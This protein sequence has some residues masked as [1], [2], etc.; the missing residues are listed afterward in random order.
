MKKK[1]LLLLV[2]V[3]ALFLVAC[4]G[5]KKDEFTLEGYA[6][7]QLV[8]LGTVETPLDPQTVYDSLTYTKEMFYGCYQLLGGES[9]QKKYASQTDY[10][11]Y[12][13]GKE[14][15]QITKVPYK[16]E[17]GERTFKTDLNYVEEYD[18]L[19]AYFYEK[20]SNSSKHVDCAY[21][22][23]NNKLVLKPLWEY[24]I[25]TENDTLKYG[26]IEDI[27]EYEFA[28]AGRSL[29][30]TM[31]DSSVNLLSGLDPD[32]ESIDIAI[33][34]VLSLNS[35]P[36]DIIDCIS[37]GYDESSDSR[38]YFETVDSKAIYSAV[39]KLEE[40][41]LFTFTIP[42]DGGTKTFQY[43]YFLCG[44]DGIVL[45]D[46]T[47]T[48][49]YNETYLTRT[50]NEI[51]S[52]LTEDQTDIL[53]EL[54]QQELEEIVTKKEDLLGDLT[55]AFTEADIK[56]TIDE[57]TGE[58]A[59]DSSVLFGGD[60]AVLTEDGK[61]F[62]NKFLE[63]YTSIIF[64]EKYDGF[65]SKTMV[66]GHTAPVSGGTYESGLPL[67]EERAN[68][69]KEYCVSTESGVDVSKLASSLEAVG[70]SNS[71]PVYD[72]NGEVD[73]AASRRVSFKFIINLEK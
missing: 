34:N 39:G 56:V 4:G 54:T 36:M 38:L 17:A 65:I 16:I 14:T 33:H 64:S 62:L 12:T 19:R 21:S 5:K 57:A 66:E 20:D 13:V 51:N 72:E 69:V 10:M 73:M 11:N 6:K 31:G 52:F 68:N 26:F 27:W 9:A 7:K 18:W 61:T 46:G 15:M 2:S 45:T 23:E 30:L 44:M 48:Y 35:K 42:V 29:T 58:L 47:N 22:V 25:D 49:Y 59:M 55:N 32:G 28:F 3:M 63:V 41:G 70:Y 24:E 67:S 50:Q 43:V 1:I 60:S 37:L 71:K 40:N 8:T 53:E